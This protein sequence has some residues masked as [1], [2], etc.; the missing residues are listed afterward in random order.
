[1]MSQARRIYGRGRLATVL[2]LGLAGILCGCSRNLVNPQIPPPGSPAFEEGYL[3]GCDSG[4]ASAD[5][6]GYTASWRK[7][8]ARYGG[9]PDYR[10][11]WDAG[12]AACYEEQWRHP[13][14]IGG[15]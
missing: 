11:G 12:L 2:L 15:R 14:T 1:M 5:R 10:R 9:E 13:K 3:E 4:F 8:E 6:P 7:D